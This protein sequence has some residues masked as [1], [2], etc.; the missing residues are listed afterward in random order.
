MTRWPAGSP[1]ETATFLV[2]DLY[3]PGG[4]FAASLD[5]DTGGV[6]GATYVWTP[7]QV[8]AV[9]GED[10]DFAIDLFDVTAKGNFEHGA[11]V[12]RLGRDIDDA[13]P[14]IVARWST[15]RARL[16]TAREDRPQPTLDDKVVAAWNGLAI[17]ALA[18][19]ESYLDDELPAE[20]AAATRATAMH[21]RQHHIVDGRLRRVSRAGVVGEPAGV[22]DDYGCVAEAFTA[23]HQ[24][25]GDGQWLESAGELLDTALARFG[26]GAGGFFDTADDAETLV[27]RPADPTDNATPSGLSSTA[28]ALLAYSALTGEA[29]YREAAQQALETVAPLVA[30]HARFAGYAA[31]AAEALVSGPYEIAVATD[32]PAD[33]LA[34]RARLL[35]PP[36][37]V[38]VAGRPDVPGVPLL[39]GRPLLRGQPTAYV[40]RGFVC[41]LPVT[42]VD[43]LATR[44]A[45]G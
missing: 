40:C 24:L 34:R 35:A 7:Q 32:D 12:L 19:L 4:G 26:D 38:V 45:A 33:V 2:R 36:G 16:L 9:L 3:R 44:L 42:D 31:A 6:E 27:A 8:R 10:A 28:A 30:Q 37:A 41:D 29:R 18:E 43:A 20:V 23:M 13:D 39:A 14:T 11:S 17:T 1:I 22:L 15:V 21:L 5:A 25:T